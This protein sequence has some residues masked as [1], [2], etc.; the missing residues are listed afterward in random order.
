MLKDPWNRADLPNV[1]PGSFPAAWLL[2]KFLVRLHDHFC[3]AS[4]CQPTHTQAYTPILR[5]DVH[6]ISIHLQ[7]DDT[8]N[9]QDDDTSNLSWQLKKSSHSYVSLKDTIPEQGGM[10]WTRAPDLEHNKYSAI[11]MKCKTSQSILYRIQ[12]RLQITL[13]SR[14]SFWAFQIQVTPTSVQWTELHSVQYLPA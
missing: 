1:C 8:S 2:P 3:T 7:D 4:D 13:P 6:P 11:L 5:L 9:I 14:A 12:F 10:I